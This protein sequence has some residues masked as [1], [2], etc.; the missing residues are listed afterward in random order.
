M[1]NEVIIG[2]RDGK[3]W[4]F[5]WDGKSMT[6]F[7]EA[8]MAADRDAFREAWEKRAADIFNSGFD[9]KPKPE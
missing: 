8:E 6:P 4:K 5:H 3:L 9:S 7:T 1:L 2:Q